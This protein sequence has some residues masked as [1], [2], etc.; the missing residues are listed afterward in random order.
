MQF[1]FAW[2]KADE[3]FD[4]DKHLKQDEQIVSLKIRH[5]E[6]EFP[7]AIIKVCHNLDYEK[8]K[9]K[10]FISCLSDGKVQLLFSGF[11]LSVPDNILSQTID[12]ELIAEP[13]N[14]IET[15][16]RETESLKKL[17]NYDPLFSKPSESN[18]VE[19]ILDGY[20][21]LPCWSRTMDSFNFSSIF[22]GR[23]TKEIGNNFA[24]DSLKVR[25]KSPPIDSITCEVSAQ[26]E[27]TY[28]STVDAGFGIKSHLSGGKL[29]TLTPQKLIENWWPSSTSIPGNT[30]HIISSQLKNGHGASESAPYEVYGDTTPYTLPAY[31][32][33]PELVLSYRIKQK[34]KETVFF[35]IQNNC[36]KLFKFRHGRNHK[37][38]TFNLEDITHDH[39]KIYWE[40]KKE[41]TKG[42]KI[43]YRNSYYVCNKDHT[44]NDFFSDYCWDISFD[45]GSALG[46]LSSASYFLTDRG[47]QSIHSAIERCQSYLAASCRAV[48]INLRLPF[49]ENIDIDCDTD[50]SFLD[51]R[52]PE[53]K[54][55]G[56]V[57]SYTIQ[58]EGITQ[59]YVDVTIL[60][61]VGN[62]VSEEKAVDF[63]TPSGIGYMDYK[64]QR[65]KQGML[66][67][68]AFRGTDI[69]QSVTV[70]NSAEQ[71][72]S[73]LAG[74]K[75]IK[76]A[77]AAKLLSSN[78]TS[79]QIRLADLNNPEVLF[80]KIDLTIPNPW[81][82]PCQIQ[83]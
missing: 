27:Q 17:P 1:F 43:T 32:L 77:A 39:Q 6:G 59:P 40:A 52:L 69:I 38:L 54:A 45:G 44:S 5:N 67:P 80:H 34:R 51:P 20:S 18:K 49:T 4:P 46:D 65:P 37:H 12:M 56:K 25:L 53:G 24:Q 30:Y 62:D 14:S 60:C 76:K 10:A 81:T 63:K 26:W 68:K 70:N 15:L 21:V 11:L 82:A 29:V 55:K 74:K 8:V 22:E 83:F 9:E 33:E 47:R 71:Q 64:D 50:L 23:K 78:S 75:F 42:E 57:V 19:E 35:D 7:S 72:N 16:A 58:A 3:D 13:L 28:Q 2:A 61:S 73:L 79:M 48:E 66:N 36:Q 41:Y 31:A